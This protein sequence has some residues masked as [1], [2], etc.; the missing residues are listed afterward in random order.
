[1]ETTT[2]NRVRYR[3]SIATTSKG[4]ISF[5]VTAEVSDPEVSQQ[6]RD[7]AI[8]IVI[9]DA[10]RMVAIL[11]GK[12]GKAQEDGIPMNVILDVHPRGSKGAE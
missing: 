4:M 6:D 9:G 12:Y 1:M 10:E 2:H 3:A 11:A 5:D 7:K 8:A